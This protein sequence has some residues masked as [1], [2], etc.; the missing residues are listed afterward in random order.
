MCFQQA[1]FSNQQCGLRTENYP[2]LS[3][4]E[5]QNQ[6]GC[7]RY[8]Y[9]NTKHQPNTGQHSVCPRSEKQKFMQGCLFKFL[10]FSSSTRFVL[11]RISQT[12]LHC[13][14]S[15][16]L[17]SDCLAREFFNVFKILVILCHPKVKDVIYFMNCYPLLE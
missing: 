4:T 11:E 3:N 13:L 7:L 2:C 8:G 9:T 12:L 14:L 6:T 16:T 1:Q 10:T 5:G 15:P 17:I